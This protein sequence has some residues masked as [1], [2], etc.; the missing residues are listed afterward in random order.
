MPPSSGTI[1]HGSLVSSSFFCCG[2]QGLM[3]LSRKPVIYAAN[4]MDSDLASGNA[5]VEAV[6]AYAAAEGN[7][8]VVVS[9][10]VCL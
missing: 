7:Q 9:A 8:V 10:Q 3:L 2:V 5:M 1:S 4:V 6:R